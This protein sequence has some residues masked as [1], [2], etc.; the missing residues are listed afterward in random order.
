[1]LQK[2]HLHF[3]EQYICK[4]WRQHKQSLLFAFTISRFKGCAVFMRRIQLFSYVSDVKH[5]PNTRDIRRVVATCKKR[6]RWEAL[7]GWYQSWACLPF[8]RIATG[9]TFTTSTAA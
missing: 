8:L 7:L 4:A 3:L 9:K 1:M 2:A 5:M 6:I